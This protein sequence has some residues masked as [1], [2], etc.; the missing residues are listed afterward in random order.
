MT[1]YDKDL[2]KGTAGFYS[3]YRPIYP[4]SLIRLLIDRFELDGKGKML[5][6]GCGTGQLTLRLSDWFEKLIGVDPEEEMLV[7][8]ERNRI[9]A[10]VDHCEWLAGKA[11]HYLNGINNEAFRLVMMAKSFHWMDQEAILEGLYT[12]IDGGGGI[13]IIDAYNPNQKSEPWQLELNRVVRNWYGE[14]RKAGS[15]TYSHPAMSYEERVS[16]SRF[17]AEVVKLPAYQYV[18]SADSIIGNVYSTSYGSRRWIG[19]QREAYETELREAL[20][21][22]HPNDSFVEE[23]QLTVVLGLK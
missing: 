19:E 14:E 1:S 2:F 8:A 9:A 10:R 11:E 16:R 13:A 15:T 17:K 22:I 18:W 7:E 5:D 12:L 23:I 20:L 21:N 4:S 6:L 3:Q